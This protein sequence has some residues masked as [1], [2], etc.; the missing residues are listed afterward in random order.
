[1]QTHI[2]KIYT[3]LRERSP[4]NQLLFYCFGRI[5]LLIVFICRQAVLAP[6]LFIVARLAQA[7]PVTSVPEQVLVPTVRLYMIHYCCLC[8]SSLP[9]TLRTKRMLTKVCS[10]RLVPCGSVSSFTCRACVFRMQRFMVFTI[11]LPVFHKHT[12]AGMLAWCFRSVRHTL[13]SHA[14]RTLRIGTPYV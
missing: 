1:M 11:L 9:Q 8:V 14:K 2:F 10:A 4:T 12:A 5:K 7:L 3:P 13:S 6:R